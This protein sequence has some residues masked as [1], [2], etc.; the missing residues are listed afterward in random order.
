MA[1]ATG[2]LVAELLT[3]REPHVDPAPYRLE[4]FHGYWF[5]G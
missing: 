5:D 4:R 2:Q 1:P 3:G